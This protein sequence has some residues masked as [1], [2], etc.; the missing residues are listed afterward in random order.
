ML[1]LLWMCLNVFCSTLLWLVYSQLVLQ[2]CRGHCLSQSWL[3]WLLWLIAS[4]LSPFPPSLLPSTQARLPSSSSTLSIA[5]VPLHDPTHA[6]FS[7]C[8]ADLTLCRFTH[9]SCSFIPLITVM[10]FL[11]HQPVFFVAPLLP[12]VSL[13]LSSVTPSVLLCHIPLSHQLLRQVHPSILS[14]H[15]HFL[16]LHPSVL[17]RL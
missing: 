2:A 15:Q 16:L 8:I 1:F 4:L 13:S 3:S 7:P 17:L 6:C 9:L 11:S 14:C 5:E 10:P 12:V